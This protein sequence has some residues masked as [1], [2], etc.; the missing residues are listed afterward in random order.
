MVV[1]QLSPQFYYWFERKAA[2]DRAALFHFRHQR[3][4]E[5]MTATRVPNAI[6][7]DNTSYTLTPSPPCGRKPTQQI[8]SS[9]IITIMTA[10]LPAV[11]LFICKHF[12]LI[13]TDIDWFALP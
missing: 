8:I 2:L 1:R 7:N 11:F 9:A 10:A 13:N 3:L 6:I 5:I 4:D 12:T